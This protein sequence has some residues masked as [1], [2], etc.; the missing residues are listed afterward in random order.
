MLGK[1]VSLVK[2]SR[3]PSAQPTLLAVVTGSQTPPLQAWVV[4][5]T[6]SQPPQ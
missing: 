3:C 6:M 1:V 5:Q 4:G 2:A